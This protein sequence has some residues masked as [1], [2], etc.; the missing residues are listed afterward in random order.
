MQITL[1]GIP[2]FS[3]PCA[4]DSVFRWSNGF[5][6]LFSGRNYYRYSEALQSIHSDYPR[7]ID[8]YWRGVPNNIDGVF[9]HCDG[10]TYFFK[11]SNYYKFNDDTLQVDPGYPKNI[12]E[13][14]TGVPDNI[15][16]VIR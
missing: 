7:S 10:V 15:D 5:L 9:R 14:W 8:E 4:V 12:S 3:G 13:F 6:Y 2:Y 16:D 11:G 1:L